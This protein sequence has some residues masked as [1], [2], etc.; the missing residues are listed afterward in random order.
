MLDIHAEWLMFELS[1][2]STKYKY[3]LFLI[4][5]KIGMIGIIIVVIFC[6]INGDLWTCYYRSNKWLIN[7][8]TAR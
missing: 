5:L 8:Y 7:I 6:E 1:L 4:I 3:A 2:I